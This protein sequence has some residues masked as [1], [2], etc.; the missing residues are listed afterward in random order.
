MK[1]RDTATHAHTQKVHSVSS[2]NAGLRRPNA[3]G[4]SD[5]AHMEVK[6]PFPTDLGTFVSL[7]V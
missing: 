1:M 7:S 5:Q 3:T 4:S 6:T 2:A